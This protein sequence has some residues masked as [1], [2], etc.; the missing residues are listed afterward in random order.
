MMWTVAPRLVLLLLG[1]FLRVCSRNYSRTFL[2]HT[3]C[4]P[5][6]DLTRAHVV[7]LRAVR[8]PPMQ[9]VL[10]ST[11]TGRDTKTVDFV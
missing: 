10:R 7:A 4:D 11:L 6:L 2:L 8:V 1:C 9:E 3:R 5:L